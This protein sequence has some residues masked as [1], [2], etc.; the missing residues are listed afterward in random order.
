MI[1]I[2]CQHETRHKHGKDRQGNQRYK[3]AFCGST[4]IDDTAKPLGELRTSMKD[5][6]LALSLLLEGLS[7]RS[8]QRLTGLCRQ[9][10]ADSDS[11]GW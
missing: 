8:V 1:V 3:C 6:T 9:T 10:L 11:A 4:F 5:A 7:I 2:A